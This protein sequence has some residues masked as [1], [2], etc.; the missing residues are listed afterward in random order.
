MQ[1]AQ[2]GAV[3]KAFVDLDELHGKTM[4][5]E[6]IFS[7]K[8]IATT[9]CVYSANLEVGMTRTQNELIQ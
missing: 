1:N 8:N 2:P 6:S 3:A 7:K 9:A 4:E 5:R